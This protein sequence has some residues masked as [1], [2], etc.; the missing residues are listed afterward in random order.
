[1]SMRF[2][3][4][5]IREPQ[6]WADWKCS[7]L[8]PLVALALRGPQKALQW[9]LFQ[10]IR[11]SFCTICWTGIERLALKLHEHERLLFPH[12][13][14]FYHLL[15]YHID[16]CGNSQKGHLGFSLHPFVTP[17]LTYSFDCG[18]EYAQRRAAAAAAKSLQSC[19]TLCDPIDGSPQAHKRRMFPLVVLA[20][21]TFQKATLFHP[22]WHQRKRGNQ[23]KVLIVRNWTSIWDAIRPTPGASPPLLSGRTGRDDSETPVSV[24]DRL[25]LAR[26]GSLVEDLSPHHLERGGTPLVEKSHCTGHCFFLS[27]KWELTVPEPPL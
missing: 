24:R 13:L 3:R 7:R 23:G 5:Q 2:L 27:Y 14:A 10:L 11:Y 1:M 6:I 20:W 21:E 22:G 8:F 18:Q 19:P 9:L 4:T 16:S 17:F 12:R 25:T 15:C 26:E